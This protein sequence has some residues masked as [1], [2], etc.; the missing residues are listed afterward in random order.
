[1]E[2]RMLLQEAACT[3]FLYQPLHY[4]PCTVASYKVSLEEQCE[5]LGMDIYWDPIK[6][7]INCAGGCWHSHFHI[8]KTA[9][10]IYL[11]QVIV[12]QHLKEI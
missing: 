7:M 1:M 11:K 6:V 10:N 5:Y 4:T 9:T 2:G 12:Q 3:D 8:S